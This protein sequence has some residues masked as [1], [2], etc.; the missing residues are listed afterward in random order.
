V[1]KL[2]LL[3][4]LFLASC[5]PYSPKHQA[6]ELASHSVVRLKL[7]SGGGGTGF[8]IT[9]ASGETVIITNRHVCGNAEYLIADG[10]DLARPTPLE[11]LE[12]YENA[13][14]CVLRAP[15][16]LTPLRISKSAPLPMEEIFVVGHPKLLGITVTD[17]VV[18]E[19]GEFPV[20]VEVESASECVGP[21]RK[22]IQVLFFEICAEIMEAT[23]ISA[24]IYPG[25]SGSPVL[26]ANGRVVGVVFA[27]GEGVALML[28][29]KDLAAVLSTY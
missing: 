16:A 14:L 17:G 18:R 4:S 5:A 1:K 22:L 13:D 20:G 9:A 28:K 10:K 26:D 21:K 12:R 25:N 19:D 8:A 27:G 2:I 3:V 15:K 24:Q 11:I 6:L 7:P 23:E 29:H